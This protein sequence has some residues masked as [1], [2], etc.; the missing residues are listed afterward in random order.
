MGTFV[1]VG[2]M[3]VKVHTVA[4]VA[5]GI[6]HGSIASIIRSIRVGAWE[7]EKIHIIQNI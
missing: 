3:A 1:E 2:E 7:D 4:I 6:I 5:F